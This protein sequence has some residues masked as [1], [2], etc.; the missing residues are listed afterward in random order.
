MATTTTTITQE[1]IDACTRVY[2]LSDNDRIFYQVRSE[3]DPLVEYKVEYLKDPRHIGKGYFTC[4]CPAGQEG[5][6][7]CSQGTC[8]H[9]RWALAAEQAYKAERKARN[10]AKARQ[11]KKREEDR[12]R[13]F[14]N[15]KP[16]DDETYDRVM[17]AKPYQ[18]TEEE[19]QRDLEQYMARPFRLLK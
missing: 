19:I 4:T 5:F 14:V 12:K 3:R 15:G 2:D 8:K 1:Q 16:V 13:F 6:A 10:E 11:A 9:V 18:P 7:H 17:N